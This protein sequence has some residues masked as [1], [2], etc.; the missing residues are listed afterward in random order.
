MSLNLSGTWKFRLARRRGEVPAKVE[1]WMEGRVPGTVHGGLER[2]GKIADPWFG[3]NEL[4]LQWIDRQDWEWMRTFAA[5]AEDC[6]RGRQDL[7]FDGLD[8]VATVFVNGR[9]VGRS[10]NMFRQ[11]VCDVR[12]SLKP[13]LN[14]LRVL[15]K[16]P[17][18]YARNEARRGKLRSVFI[19][20]SLAFAKG[21]RARADWQGGAIWRRGWRA[22]GLALS[23][24]ANPS[25]G[26]S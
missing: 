17:T 6:A 7:I 20:V 19:Y 10:V 21:Y 1:R 26:T 13:G 12:A 11:V 24:P 9:K 23:L 16:S 15:L 3:M 18:H 25:G 2:A 14:D 4:D 5:T 8:T 22:G